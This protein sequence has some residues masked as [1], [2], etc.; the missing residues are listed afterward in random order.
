[1][2]GDACEGWPNIGVKFSSSTGISSSGTHTVSPPIQYA[3]RLGPGRGREIISRARPRRTGLS[4]ASIPKPSTD[5]HMGAALPA[6][7]GL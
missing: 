6:G 2:D 1:M 4:A 7:V 3:S 5:P